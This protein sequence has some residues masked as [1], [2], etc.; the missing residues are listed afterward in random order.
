MASEAEKL[1]GDYWSTDAI[2][3]AGDF[4]VPAYIQPQFKILQ[5][6][7][8]LKTRKLMNYCKHLTNSKVV[9]LTQN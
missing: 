6:P 2:C 3:S 7:L 1:V 5:L 8:D 4:P 9:T